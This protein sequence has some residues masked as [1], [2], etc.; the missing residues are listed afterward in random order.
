MNNAGGFGRLRCSCVL[1]FTRANM[2]QS[3]P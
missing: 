2:V 3:A 1:G